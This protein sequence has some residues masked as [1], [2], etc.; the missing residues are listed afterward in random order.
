MILDFFVRFDNVTCLKD[1][2]N[3][4]YKCYDLKE[5]TNQKKKKNQGFDHHKCLYMVSKGIT[6]V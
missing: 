3:I 1:C 2:G 4:L 6:D 5:N